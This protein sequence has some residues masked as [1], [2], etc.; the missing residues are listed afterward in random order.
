MRRVNQKDYRNCDYCHKRK[1]KDKLW[2]RVLDHRGRYE[3]MC[4]NCYKKIFGNF[5]YDDEVK[6]R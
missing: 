2:K 5:P 1:R 6:R 3:L 4:E